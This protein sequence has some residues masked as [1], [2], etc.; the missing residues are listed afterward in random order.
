MK[1]WK[2]IFLYSVILFLVIFSIGGI[3]IIEKI[4]K[5]NLQEA[6]ESTIYKYLNT[7]S[8]MNLNTDKLFDID[9]DNDSNLKNWLNI[10]I[11]GYSMK[12]MEPYYM[13]VYTDDNK[14]I[15][16][17]LKRKIKGERKEI[18][19]AKENKKSFIIRD[20]NNDKY[21]FVS[22]IINFKNRELKLI[23]SKNIQYVYSQRISNYEF[24]AIIYLITFIILAAIM[25][26]ISKNL[27]NP[28][29]KLSNISKDIAKG[30]Y[31]KR[32][33][34]SN[35]THEIGVLE[36]NFNIMIDVIEDKI[37]ELNFL[38]QSKQ[39][40]IDS[41]SHEI[42]TPIT[43]IIG[44]SDLLLKSNVNEETKIKA[45]SY[46]NSEARRLES[47]NSTLLRFALI[48]EEQTEMTNNYIRDIVDN[49]ISMM[50]YKLE[51]KNI[52]IDIN[53]EDKEI[54]A[55]RQLMIVLISNIIDNGIK[56]SEE[57]KLI[58]VIGYS[59]NNENY[60]LKIKDYGIG[61]PKEDLDKILEP[62]YMVDKARTRKNNGIG[63]GLSICNEICKIHNISLDIKSEVD[64]GTQVILTFNKECITN[65][66]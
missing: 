6:I 35:T 20:I 57:S 61:I 7:E 2:K 55:D 25:Y 44:Y 46:I 24:F 30:D 11:N 53:I 13:E 28:L 32:A 10:T 58:K 16:S 42:K 23:I 1:F 17:N 22:S 18:T 34:E 54:Y 40:F 47:L 21:V 33:E 5:D 29:V 39:R 27:T 52:K 9:V 8:M 19:E 50:S 15:M 37:E 14:E 38:N 63:L 64:M 48:R 4:H 60:I 41:L 31:S 36:N 26:I 12:S 51:Q 56:A 3:A 65:E 59:D 62:F 45:L 49:A 43:S 66:K